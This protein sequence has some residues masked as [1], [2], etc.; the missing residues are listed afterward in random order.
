MYLLSLNKWSNL[1]D[2]IDYLQFL[3]LSVKQVLN[4]YYRK[5]ILSGWK[6]K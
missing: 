1:S 3:F 4:K 2:Q 6:Y 5:F